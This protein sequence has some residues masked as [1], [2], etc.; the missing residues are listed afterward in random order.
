MSRP[1]DAKATMKVGSPNS[2]N[3]GIAPTPSRM[4]AAVAKIFSAISR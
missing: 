3:S 1:G 4:V 2:V